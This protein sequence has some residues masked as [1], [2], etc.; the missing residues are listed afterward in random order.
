MEINKKVLS[1]DLAKKIIGA[2]VVV[3]MLLFFFFPMVNLFI[4]AFRDGAFSDK[5]L[6]EKF[7]LKWFTYVL[8]RP[9]ILDSFVM[10]FVVAFVT[11]LASMAICIPAAYAFA[12]LDF[13]GKRL[14]YFS[15]LLSNAFPRIGLYVSI[16]VMFYKFNLM[17]TFVGVIIIHV[18]NS[19]MLMIWISSSAFKNV[20]KEQEEAARDVGASSLRTFFII[21]LPLAWPGIMVASLFTFLGSMEEGAGTLLVGLPNI[22]TLPVEMYSVIFDYPGTAGAALALML[23]VPILV[24]LIV[25]MKLLGSKS[26][27]GSM[28]MN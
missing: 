16:G 10:S 11:T 18:L 24:I 14:C 27:T 15:F 4:D 2:I 12:R 13:V 23:L 6:P 1:Y 3:V 19:L 7:S 8:E 25:A 21:T 9:G 20:H 28:K 17:G 5:Y 26:I 22:K